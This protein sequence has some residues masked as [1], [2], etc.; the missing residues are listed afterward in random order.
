MPDTF[1]IT[2]IF[3]IL[4]AAVGAIVRRRTKDNCLKDFAGFMI[5]LEKNSGKTVRGKL[6]VENTGLELVYPQAHRNDGAA[7]KTSYL[8]YK[9]EFP[10]ITALI[11]YHD[12]LSE[13]NKK[14]RD[15]QLKKIYH[16]G[17]LRKTNRKILNIFKTVR[18]S[19][20]EIINLLLTQ[21][22]RAVPGGAVLATQ[23]KY[24]STMKQELTGSI[25]TSFEPLLEK[26]IGRKVVLEII[27]NDKIFEY[28]GVLKDYTAEFIEILDANY[29]PQDSAEPKKADLAVRRKCGVVRGLGE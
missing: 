28:S 18:D 11:R 23:D 15:E 4:A 19:V 13:E 7:E 21:A 1:A 2:I 6:N 10:G 26:Y 16:P 22:K 20:I 25:G 12:Q 29:A 24:V 5:T 8:L 27:K 3:I 17:F 9:Y 14:Q